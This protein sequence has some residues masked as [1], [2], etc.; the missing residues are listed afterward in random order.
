MAEE[1]ESESNISE[2]STLIARYR[3]NETE[4][5]FGASM[6]PHQNEHLHPNF[7]S[8]SA[9]SMFG[10]SSQIIVTPN[11]LESRTQASSS[12]SGRPNSTN[13]RQEQL[14]RAERY[15]STAV[16]V[17]RAYV[18][19]IT[20]LWLVSFIVYMVLLAL[21]HIPTAS[22]VGNTFTKPNDGSENHHHPNPTYKSHHIPMATS[23]PMTRATDSIR[24]TIVDP[25]VSSSTYSSMMEDNMESD[26]DISAKEASGTPK[27]S[28]PPIS[29]TIQSLFGS[30]FTT[31]KYTA[32]P[33]LFGSE[34]GQEVIMPVV[35]VKNDGCR[36]S[37]QSFP[38][39]SLKQQEWIKREQKKLRRGKANGDDEHLYDYE[40]EGYDGDNDEDGVIYNGLFRAT[41]DRYI[42]SDNSQRHLNARSVNTTD[43][44]APLNWIALVQRGGCPFD[45]KVYSLWKSGFDTVIVYNNHA[46]SYKSIHDLRFGAK[47]QS[48]KTRIES[49]LQNSDL[50]LRMSAHSSFYMMIDVISMFMTNRDAT[51]LLEKAQEVSD[52]R[53]E[54]LVLKLSPSTWGFRARNGTLFGFLIDML[55]LFVS[56]VLCGTIFLVSCL[57]LSVVRNFALA[58]HFFFVETLVEGCNLIL[59][60]HP[61]VAP[62]PPSLKKIPFPILKMTQKEIDENLETNSGVCECCAIC[63]DDF[64][65]GCEYR[66]FPCR[67][68]FHAT[69]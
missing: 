15:I 6:A 50:P 1:F 25:Y 3:R 43:D 28:L 53:N 62:N 12:T 9:S 45:E 40:D 58:G 20:R 8:G 21:R 56:V 26:V 18:T 24:V 32:I 37:K 4:H 11:D 10:S 27:E 57:I 31:T 64:E 33:A 29:S 42:N 51:M 49:V 52:L 44:D 14:E 65:A 35:V 5:S 16:L 59:N 47:P 13:F 63:I 2:T 48:Y 34:L 36:A 23:V 38:T 61:S 17:F 60:Q 41:D 67:H 22:I 54:T 39:L 7:Y 55:F 46:S 68:K 19:M 69:W 66:E 30:L